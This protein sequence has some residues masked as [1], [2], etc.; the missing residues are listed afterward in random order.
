MKFREAVEYFNSSPASVFLVNEGTY[1]AKGSEGV[2]KGDLFAV[3][4][5]K[6]EP[7]LQVVIADSCGDQVIVSVPTKTKSEFAFLPKGDS[8]LG[9]KGSAIQ[10]PIRRWEGVFKSVEEYLKLREGHCFPMPA[11][12]K[13]LNEAVDHSKRQVPA[14][15]LLFNIRE[16]S[17]RVGLR[18]RSGMEGVDPSGTV[19]RF[20]EGE[21]PLFFTTKLYDVKCSPVYFA[22]VVQFPQLAR[23]YLHPSTT[24]EADL[25][26]NLSTITINEVRQDQY[27]VVR[28]LSD[29]GDKGKRSG[30]PER[31]NSGSHYFAIPVEAEIEVVCVTLEDSALMDRILANRQL[32]MTSE[33][34][35]P[36]VTTAVYVKSRMESR[37]P[38]ERE[39]EREEGL[40]VEELSLQSVE[41]ESESDTEEVAVPKPRSQS[42]GVL[43]TGHYQVPTTVPRKKK[44]PYFNMPVMDSGSDYVNFQVFGMPE[45]NRKGSE[46]R[47]S[48]ADSK[49]PPQEQYV[50]MLQDLS[51]Q[52]DSSVQYDYADKTTVAEFV[53]SKSRCDPRQKPVPFPREH[54]DGRKGGLVA[55]KGGRPHH[56]RPVVRQSDSSNRSTSPPRGNLT[57][58]PPHGQEHSPPP[59]LGRRLAEEN[60]GATVGD[61]HR[62]TEGV[63]RRGSLQACPKGPQ[64]HFHVATRLGQ[65]WRRVCTHLGLQ[66]HQLD[67]VDAANPQLQSKAMEALRMWLNGHEDFRAPHSWETLLQALRRAG[68]WDMASELED[69]I[70]S[71]KL[72]KS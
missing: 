35:P 59:V 18:K 33:E 72:L 43:G 6:R 30:G 8:I 42:A 38:E 16:V 27:F 55:Q 66:D 22:N 17:Q 13:V 2:K 69:D 44:A 24:D 14:Q 46:R 64:L 48:P 15:T 61:E 26:P 39:R 58:V 12:L 51:T 23:V 11:A 34:V 54:R 52:S 41:V 4:L 1:H 21:E 29:S 3:C 5:E 36:S 19:H 25:L 62:K 67:Q 68:Q 32:T 60:D 47:V 50:A 7:R 65:D 49:S 53:H 70:R 10:E 63:H 37:V 28:T 31:R 9:S 56:S 40:R 71:G 45:D 20:L 57:R